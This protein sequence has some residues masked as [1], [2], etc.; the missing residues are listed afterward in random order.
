M[1]PPA[2][3]EVGSAL[4]LPLAVAESALPDRRRVGTGAAGATAIW[5]SGVKLGT[6][7]AGVAVGAGVEFRVAVSGS[8]AILT[9]AS[10][11]WVSTFAAEGI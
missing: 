9:G 8:D 1:L 7:S 10:K 5:A 6:I 11:D 3:D 4:P 2:L